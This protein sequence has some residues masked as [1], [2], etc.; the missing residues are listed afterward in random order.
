MSNEC[1]SLECSFDIWATGLERNCLRKEWELPFLEMR[2]NISET[3]YDNASFTP[4]PQGV[5]E[6]GGIYEQSRTDY[7][8]F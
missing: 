7:E 1:Q 4:L 3:T 8:G 2:S 6:K 5:R